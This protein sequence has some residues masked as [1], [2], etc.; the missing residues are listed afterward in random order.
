MRIKLSHY[1]KKYIENITRWRKDI[2]FIF[3]WKKNNILRTNGAALFYYILGFHT[4]PR[5]TKDN[6]HIVYDFANSESKY[7]LCSKVA[8][9]RCREIPV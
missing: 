5:D 3:E 7:L 9:I 1:V 4:I 6:S 2:N 8:K